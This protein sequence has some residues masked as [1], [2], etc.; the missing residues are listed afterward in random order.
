MNAAAAASVPAWFLT[1]EVD[2]QLYALPADAVAEVIRVPP[3]ARVPQAP[4]ALLGV[5][6]LRGAVLPMASLHVML[7][8]Q[9]R[10][11]PSARAIVLDIGAPAA[12]VV[13]AVSA[14]E[15]TDPARIES[16]P[17]EDSG[18]RLLGAFAIAGHRRVARILDIK[19]MLEVAFARRREASPRQPSPIAVVRASHQRI[20]AQDASEMLV[21]FEVAG[22]EFAL[23]LQAVQEILA[24][25]GQVTAV[26][27]A[28]AAVVGITSL[29]DRLL[30]LLS[31][32]TLLGLAAPPLA[33]APQKVVVLRTGD[34][35]VGLVVD[36]AR[37]VLSAGSGEMDPVP[38]VLAAR[39]G[40]ESRIQSIFRAEGGRRLISILSPETLFRK[41][42]M[43]QLTNAR[44]DT[45]AG[46]ALPGAAAGAERIFIVFRL[47]ESEYGLSIENV[48]E[49]APVPAQITRVPRTPRFLEGVVNLR[50][51]VLPVVD[52]RRRFDMPAHD[53]KSAQ[54]LIVVRTARHRAGIIV[55]GVSDVLRTGEASIQPPPE[56]TDSTSR[57]IDGVVNLE[58][59]GRLILLLD[60]AELLTRTEQGL[61]DAFQATRKKAGA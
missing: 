28:D 16:T 14:L 46:D 3:M 41:E 43:Q 51:E 10:P 58:A 24:T 53:A 22:Q 60:P 38:P 18:P 27:R 49:V 6:N 7:G 2:T 20:A 61:L 52:Q 34:S 26:T 35:Q 40:G 29:R 15:S 36:R 33:D 57:L 12:I 9:V 42:V 50:G 1:F 55:D 5:A 25:P 56:L 17:D 4:A 21:T 13:D 59:S 45:D 44:S 37:S 19:A 54:R 23:P 31:M 39:T 32:H 47:G 48:V 11:A 8:S 30:P